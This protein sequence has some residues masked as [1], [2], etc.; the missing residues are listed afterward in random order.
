MELETRFGTLDPHFD[1][2]I[3]TTRHDHRLA[4]HLARRGT[5]HQMCHIHS[6]SSIIDARRLIIMLDLVPAPDYQAVNDFRDR[7]TYFA[8]DVNFFGILPAPEMVEPVVDQKTVD[9][10]ANGTLRV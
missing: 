9:A 2:D 4:G 3:M 10:A 5:Q 8:E 6:I 7:N 1:C